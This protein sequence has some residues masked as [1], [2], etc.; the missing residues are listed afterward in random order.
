[1]KYCALALVTALFIVVGCAPKQ[2]KKP[3][4]HG[5]ADTTDECRYM[6]RVCRE[7]NEFQREFESFSKEA[8]DEL[9][10][11]LNGYFDN[12]ERAADLCKESLE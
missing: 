7:A 2:I 5:L 4:L 3:N 8:Q 11:A 10:P 9:I 6:I 1:M 12:C